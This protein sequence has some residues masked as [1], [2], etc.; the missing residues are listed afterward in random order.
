MVAAARGRPD[1]T[2]RGAQRPADASGDVAGYAA[3]DYH[4]D[5]SSPRQ[6]SAHAREDRRVSRGQFFSV[7]S[8]AVNMTMTRRDFMRQG[9]AM[10]AAAV[11][12]Q[13]FG[14]VNA[15]AQSGGYQALVCIFLFGGN[16]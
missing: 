3:G 14:L 7:S 2:R 8:G 1:G 15:L 12:L 4:R 10:G 11:A 5:S 9:C 16:D 13:R 6:Q